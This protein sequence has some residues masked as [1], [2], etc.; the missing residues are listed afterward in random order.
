LKNVGILMSNALSCKADSP[1]EVVQ[2]PVFNP[3]SGGQ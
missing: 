3:Q 1:L 2:K